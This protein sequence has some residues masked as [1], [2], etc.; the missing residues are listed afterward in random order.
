MKRLIRHYGLNATALIGAVRCGIFGG[1]V[2][3]HCLTDQPS[4]HEAD[5]TSQA[6]APQK[7]MGPLLGP[8][9][10]STDNGRNLGRRRLDALAWLKSVAVCHRAAWAALAK[11]LQT[12][13]VI[14]AIASSI[15]AISDCHAV[16]VHVGIKSVRIP[17]KFYL[18][19]ES[20]DM[21]GCTRC[22]RKISCPTRQIGKFSASLNINNILRCERGLMRRMGCCSPIAVYFWPHH[23]T[24]RTLLGI[25]LT[26][27]IIN[28]NDNVAEPTIGVNSQLSGRGFSTVPPNRR[29]TPIPLS[30][31]GIKFVESKYSTRENEGALVGNEG[32]AG[33]LD[34]AIGGDVQSASECCNDNSGECGDRAVV[35]I[36]KL[37]CTANVPVNDGAGG[38]VFFGG[39]LFVCIFILAHAA[40]EDRRKVAFYKKE[41]RH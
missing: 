24:A 16:G 9:G 36:Q 23:A 29:N 28:R 4:R 40:L 7:G 38:Y 25:D 41:R 32:F 20:C 34:L 18:P 27:P 12:A 30:S 3:Y 15:M 8:D 13:F 10:Q 6:T 1:C 39:I 22:G 17:Y 26:E 11:S 21:L 14:G 37:T 31:S 33:Q 35:G 5:S 2:E 19:T